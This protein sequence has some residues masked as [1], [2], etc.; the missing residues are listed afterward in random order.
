MR[1]LSTMNILKKL[2]T[3][4]YRPIDTTRVTATLN[5]F[6]ERIPLI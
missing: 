2:L 4:A 3:E 5:I 1:A 6:G